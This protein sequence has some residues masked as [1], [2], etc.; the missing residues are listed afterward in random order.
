MNDFI[1]V[2][3]RAFKNTLACLKLL[4]ILVLHILVYGL[5]FMAGSILIGRI[6]GPVGFV[7]GII[8]AI[9]RAMVF[10][11]LLYTLDS[12][13][14]YNRIYWKNLVEGF[15][16]YLSP[17]ISVYFAYYII[18]TLIGLVTSSIVGLSPAILIIKNLAMFLVF[19]AAGEYI[20][21]G[22]SYSYDAVSESLSLNVKEPIN[23]ALFNGLLYIGL[24]YL[25]IDINIFSGSLGFG[26]YNILEAIVLSAYLIYKGHLFKELYMSNKRKREYMG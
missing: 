12:I 10:S 11:H 21:I 19:S 23:W 18:E 16:K 14:N 4:P 7:G 24:I 9:L 25:G 5:I 2:N 1:R 22:G 3:T 20:Y 13:V 15:T 8:M 6:L 17:A 26:I